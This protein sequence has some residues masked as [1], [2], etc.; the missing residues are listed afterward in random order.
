MRSIHSGQADV[1]E[2]DF[3]SPF[4]NADAHGRIEGINSTS[5]R[6]HGLVECPLIVDAKRVDETF[7]IDGS[8]G[9]VEADGLV[10]VRRSDSFAIPNIEAEIDGELTRRAVCPVQIAE[11]LLGRHGFSYP[12]LSVGGVARV[13]AADGRRN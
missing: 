3:L 5:E 7:I 10:A 11:D 6:F 1:E 8:D 2:M 9:F 4:V 13:C 12:V